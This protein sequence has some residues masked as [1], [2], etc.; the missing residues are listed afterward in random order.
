MKSMQVLCLFLCFVLCLVGCGEQQETPTDVTA[1]Q[2]SAVVSVSESSSKAVPDV[3]SQ[4]PVSQTTSSQPEFSS[5]V[6]SDSSTPASQPEEEQVPVPF[7]FTR[8]SRESDYYINGLYTTSQMEFSFLCNSYKEWLAFLDSEKAK[9]NTERGTE[10]YAWNLDEY[11]RAYFEQGKSIL[12]FPFGGASSSQYAKV[13]NMF[14]LNNV[15]NVQ[16][17][18]YYP[19]DTCN[20]L[21]NKLYIVEMNQSLQSVDTV[22]Y[23]VGFYQQDGIDGEYVQY[24][25]KE[26]DFK[27]S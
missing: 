7:T 15:L 3:E 20:D 22:H 13:K 18:F 14:L 16:M 2:Q 8:G 9:Y 19:N 1:N 24:Q 17:E 6:S 26:Y 12:I 10:W 25:T 4:E 23:T 21:I 11:S 27:V 5:Q